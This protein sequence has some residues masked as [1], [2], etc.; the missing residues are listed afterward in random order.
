M[1]TASAYPQVFTF[2]EN[3]FFKIFFNS[4]HITPPDIKGKNLKKPSPGTAALKSRKNTERRNIK[5]WKGRL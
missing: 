2:S 5:P 3:D 4:P 1:L